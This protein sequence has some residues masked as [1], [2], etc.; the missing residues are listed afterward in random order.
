MV[1][2][3]LLVLWPAV[4][5]AREGHTW[6]A[7]AQLEEPPLD[8][9]DA[10]RTAALG[11]PE[12]RG[13]PLP[14]QPGANLDNAADVTVVARPG[15]PWC[16][17]APSIVDVVAAVLARGGDCEVWFQAWRTDSREQGLSEGSTRAEHWRLVAQR[18]VTWD[19]SLEDRL[20]HF[21]LRS[22]PLPMDAGDCFGWHFS[23]RVGAIPFD[24][25]PGDDGQPGTDRWS[26]WFALGA[27][28]VRFGPREPL[29]GWGPMARRYP[30][31][32]RLRPLLPNVADLVDGA[33]WALRRPL[34]AV[35]ANVWVPATVGSRIRLCH[36]E[37]LEMAGCA[38]MQRS[39][40]AATNAAGDVKQ[41]RWIHWDEILSTLCEC[42]SGRDLLGKAAESGGACC[43]PDRLDDAL[44][45]L[46]THTETPCLH[47][48]L[49]V[50]ASCA[51]KLVL[52]HD[53]R[54]SRAVGGEELDVDEELV[55]ML[56]RR[57][58]SVRVREAPMVGIPG[59]V[60]ALAWDVTVT[61]E[62]LQ[63]RSH[64]IRAPSPDSGLEP[65]F[66]PFPF[67]V[68]DLLW[69]WR[70]AT[71]AEL[72]DVLTSVTT[73][74]RAH[75][76]ELVPFVQSLRLLDRE[77]AE[78]AGVAAVGEGGAGTDGAGID[79]VVWH[80]QWEEVLRY[81][82]AWLAADSRHHAVVSHRWVEFGMLWDA[83]ATALSPEGVSFEALCPG[84]ARVRVAFVL[85]AAPGSGDGGEEPLIVISSKDVDRPCVWLASDLF[86]VEVHDRLPALLRPAR[87]RS[88]LTYWAAAR[89]ELVPGSFGACWPEFQ[90]A[91]EQVGRPA[92]SLGAAVLPHCAAEFDLSSQLSPA[93]SFYTLYDARRVSEHVAL[94]HFVDKVALKE[95]LFSE[96]I[97]TAR[98]LYKSYESPDVKSLLGQWSRYALKAAHKHHGGQGVLI[99]DN[100]VNLISKQPLSVDEIQ[101]RALEMWTPNED[102]G[103][104]HCFEAAGRRQC[105]RNAPKADE[106]LRPAILIEELALPWDGRPGRL[107]DEAFCFVSWGRLLWCG[108]MGPGSVWAGYVMRDG[109]PV[110]GQTMHAEHGV[111]NDV[112]A[113]LRPTIPYTKKKF[114]EVVALAERVAMLLQADFVR[115]DIFP[116]AG[117]PLVA[118]VSIVS[119][120]LGRNN[121]KWGE[122][123]AWMLELFR[124]RWLEG[125]AQ[126]RGRIGPL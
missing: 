117:R 124:E 86:P 79:G 113:A 57:Q 6:L 53:Q 66:A 118:E 15:G 122:I 92:A 9:G 28:V 48:A 103:E 84:C 43:D 50:I 46:T 121:L 112:G 22:N 62:N 56:K 49:A 33:S 123:D 104:E 2:V 51:A 78:A 119:G 36:P 27:K 100:G 23:G 97:P 58:I 126:S 120:W 90:A 115:V 55:P 87:P 102:V 59:T 108:V 99:M 80:D 71:S 42:T 1:M 73:G 72:L 14:L 52:R 34:A 89:L 5:A 37:S 125:Y 45:L 39:G 70:P 24:I 61:D 107:P 25:P 98:M 76:A 93:S 67:G 41:S 18:R 94:T 16:A 38:K 8:G 35:P 31:R 7:A 110:Y 111:R 30:V 65:S 12:W 85:P 21:D 106:G 83:G 109:T 40:L 95:R 19:A 81:V 13:E 60:D 4:V 11:P 54:P 47:G 10:A 68:R 69:W 114:A 116:N 82:P 105:V 101:A 3:L 63:N 91:A 75:G 77:A 74:L 32:F 44:F 26:K 29:A 20:V 96:G 17:D 64:R 88:L